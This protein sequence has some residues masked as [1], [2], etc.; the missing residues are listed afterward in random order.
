[1]KKCVL[2]C[3]AV[4]AVTSGCGT[5]RDTVPLRPSIEGLYDEVRRTKSSD[6][7]NP[8]MYFLFLETGWDGIPRVIAKLDDFRDQGYW[9]S[10][11]FKDGRWQKR[12]IRL[13]DGWRPDPSGYFDCNS[14]GFYMLT[15][16]G[17]KPQLVAIH[18][19]QRYADVPTGMATCQEAFY[20]TIDDEGSLKTIPIPE[21]TLMDVDDDSEEPSLGPFPRIKLKSPN[22]K[23]EPVQVETFHPKG[24]ENESEEDTPCLTRDEVLRPE[25]IEPDFPN[26]NRSRLYAEVDLTGNGRKDIIIEGSQAASGTG[27]KMWD[28]YLCVSTNQYRASPVDFFGWPLALEDDYWDG[29]RVWGYWR[30]SGSCGSV[31]YLYFDEGECKRSPLLEIHPGDGGSGIGNAIYTAIFKGSLLPLRLLSPASPTNDLPYQDTAWEWT[32]PFRD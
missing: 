10:F 12:P 32:I 5:K 24:F 21:F 29:V 23:L 18:V 7:E 17:Q 19:W 16:K 28:V 4:I 27:G 25:A 26:H 30:T 31:W 15:E 6:F 9:D 1:M 2:L 3:F 14:D 11:D 20:I 13:I 8:E 22:D